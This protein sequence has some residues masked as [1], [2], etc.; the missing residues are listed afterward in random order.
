VTA[1]PEDEAPDPEVV[2]RDRE[3][4]RGKMLSLLAMLAFCAGVMALP[5]GPLGVPGLALA[6]YVRAAARRDLTKIAEGTMD[7]E[8]AQLTRAALHDATV[9]AVLSGAGLVVATVVAVGLLFYLT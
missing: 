9:G 2:R 4:H 6:L 5:S 3:R 1:A 7:P 8:G